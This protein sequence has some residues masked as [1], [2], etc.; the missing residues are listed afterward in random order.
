L[1]QQL[2]RSERC[3]RLKKA[4]AFQIRRYVYAR[5]AFWRMWRGSS[6]AGTIGCHDESALFPAVMLAL[7]P[8]I[9]ACR[10]VLITLSGLPTKRLKEARQ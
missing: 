8:V 7:P 2:T 1:F 5:R 3:P 6:L 10:L 4:Q 9:Y